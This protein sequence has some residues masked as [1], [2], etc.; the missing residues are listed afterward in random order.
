MNVLAELNYRLNG[1]DVDS[2]Q[3]E[4]EDFTKTTRTDD[5]AYY[6]VEIVPDKSVKNPVYKAVY[7]LDNFG[8]KPFV[9]EHCTKGMTCV[10]IRFTVPETKPDE[11]QEIQDALERR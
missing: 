10:F 6:E 2:M 3:F 1:Y 9:V 11:K 8:N 4:I 5:T 7:A